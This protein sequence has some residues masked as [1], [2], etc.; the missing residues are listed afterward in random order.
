[1]F[2]ICVWCLVCLPPLILYALALVPNLIWSQYSLVTWNIVYK[3][4]NNSNNWT[5]FN[6]Q[7]VVLWHCIKPNIVHRARVELAIVNGWKYEFGKETLLKGRIVWTRTREHISR[8]NYLFVIKSINLNFGFILFISFRI[9][10]LFFVCLM[11]FSGWFFFSLLQIWSLITF[12]QHKT[13]NMISVSPLRRFLFFHP[14]FFYIYI[15]LFNTCRWKKASLRARS[16]NM[17]FSVVWSY[18]LCYLPMQIHEI[19]I[20]IYK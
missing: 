9:Q 8:V 7:P 18:V 11:T 10:L 5:L 3:F 12:F 1:M 6:E 14:L 13:R 17:F 2:G 15:N 4:N 20:Y 19:E 16:Y